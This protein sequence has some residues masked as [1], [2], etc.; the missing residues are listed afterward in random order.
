MGVSLA[1]F[2]LCRVPR[3]TLLP[4]RYSHHHR[5]HLIY[6]IVKRNR[7]NDPLLEN[8]FFPRSLSRLGQPSCSRRARLPAQINKLPRTADKATTYYLSRVSLLLFKTFSTSL[9]ICFLPFAP[10]YIV[11]LFKLFRV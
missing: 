1:G 7:N 6:E 10:L 9:R 4:G 5:H 3:F 11:H 8:D 2:A